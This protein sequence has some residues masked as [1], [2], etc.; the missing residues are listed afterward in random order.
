MD[1]F[2]APQEQTSQINQ[3]LV[4]SQWQAAV[5]DQGKVKNAKL[6]AVAPRALSPGTGV[7]GSSTKQSVKMRNRA[8]LC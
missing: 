4:S 6:V 5:F 2:F 7:S 8:A 1:Q 3:S